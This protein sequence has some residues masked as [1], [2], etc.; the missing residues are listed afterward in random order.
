[1]KAINIPTTHG[2]FRAIFSE[3][4][5]AR[6]DFPFQ[7][8]S[9]SRDKHEAPTVSP[10]LRRWL[11]A[12]AFALKRV[13][14]GQKPEALPPLDWSAGTDFQRQVWAVMSKIEPGRT[15]TY[16]EIAVAI[17]K[18]RASRAVGSAC[19]A[20]P[21]PVLVPCHRVLAA[22]GRLGGFSSGLDWKRKLLAGEGIAFLANPG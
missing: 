9:S 8:S 17:G 3:R 7:S 20:N 1:M 16:S 19:G 6:L 11:K 13:L 4:G 14:A 21:I 22:G 18:P 2:V 15:M 12:T 5:L 10:Q